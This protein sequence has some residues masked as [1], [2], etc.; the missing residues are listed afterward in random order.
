MGYYG[1]GFPEYESVASKREKAK[2]KLAELR[3][4]NPNIKPVSIEGNIISQSW[5][6]KAWNSNLEQYADFANRMGRGRSY[7]RNGA[8]LDLQIENGKIHALV[9]GSN[10]K[11]YSVTISIT[12]LKK[13]IWNSIR[14]KCEGKLE[15][16]EELIMGRFPKALSEI[17]TKKSNGLFPS[18]KEIKFECSCPDWAS[19][20]KHVAAVLYGVSARLDNDPSLFFIL[21][22]TDMNKLISQTLE[23]KSQKLLKKAKL[24]STR[25]IKEEDLSSM[26]GI[27]MIKAKRSGEST[28]STKKHSV[29][30]TVKKKVKR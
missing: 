9:Q 12:P 29:K 10:S 2:K 26:F 16:V 18:P 25:I 21:R 1:Y 30:R 15:S 20:C 23:N 28:P 6:G 5:W 8:V 11:P 22:N 24:K 14:T 27:E 3:K 7:V 13:T 19:M 17:F 4:K